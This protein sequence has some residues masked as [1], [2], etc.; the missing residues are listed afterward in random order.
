MEFKLNSS[1]CETF[2]N[3]FGHIKM[4][5]GSFFTIHT[6]YT[7]FSHLEE[8]V[9]TLLEELKKNHLLKCVID[10]L[11][12]TNFKQWK[13]TI[14]CLAG[15]ITYHIDCLIQDDGE[16]ILAFQILKHPIVEYKMDEGINLYDYFLKSFI[17]EDEYDDIISFEKSNNISKK[18]NTLK[19]LKKVREPTVELTL[20]E[21]SLCRIDDDMNSHYEKQISAIYYI[22]KIILERTVLLEDEDLFISLREVIQEYVERD[23]IFEDVKNLAKCAWENL[24]RKRITFIS[25]LKIIQNNHKNLCEVYSYQKDDPK[26]LYHSV[27]GLVLSDRNMHTRILFDFF[28]KETELNQFVINFS[29]GIEQDPKIDI[30]NIKIHSRTS[31]DIK[32]YFLS[33]IDAIIN[34]NPSEL[35]MLEKELYKSFDLP[36]T[37]ENNKRADIIIN[38]AQNIKELET[39]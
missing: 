32:V 16:H 19:P 23:D 9:F 24:P 28:N 18:R 38:H 14:Y 25:L 27:F 30:K 6:N 31:E 37:I 1:P 12:D 13:V 15:I 34:C 4:K 11:N 36:N 35:H 2:D 26:T 22:C 8:H 7:L 29:E 21:I 17:P 10:Y 33:L 39:Y 5:N 20:R 3:Y